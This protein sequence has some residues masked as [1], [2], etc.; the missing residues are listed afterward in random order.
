ML[1]DQTAWIAATCVVMPVFFA[2]MKRLEKRQ[3]KAAG[4]VV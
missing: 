1:T 4:N 2:I 3:A